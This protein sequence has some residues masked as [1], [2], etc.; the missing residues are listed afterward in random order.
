MGMWYAQQDC[1]DN[2]N[3]FIQENYIDKLGDELIYNSMSEKAKS[4]PKLNFSV[5]IPET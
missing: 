1:Q 3:M 4:F 5:N 2:C